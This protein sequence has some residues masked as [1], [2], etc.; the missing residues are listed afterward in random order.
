MSEFE[1]DKKTQGIFVPFVLINSLTQ[2]TSIHG[3]DY[4]MGMINEM[5][6]NPNIYY[7]LVKSFCPTIYG[8][9]LIKAG[10]LLGILGGSAKNLSDE[11]TFRETS[12]I[13]LLGDP[14]LGKSQL[15]K[16]AVELLP[17]SIYVSATATSTAG[18]TVAVNRDNN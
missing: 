16:F 5:K 11:S 18:L 8:Q 14:G 10:L 2:K 4:D 7:S 15:L 1:K 3:T 17:H 12:H 6:N 9:E 13:L